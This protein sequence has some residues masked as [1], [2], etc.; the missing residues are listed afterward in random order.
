MELLMR[1]LISSVLAMTCCTASAYAQDEAPGPAADT[2]APSDISGSFGG[3]RIEGNV[4]WDKLQAF[5]RNNEKLG[6]GGSLG[7]DGNVNNVITIGPEF[8]YWQPNNHRSTVDSPA[9]DIA[10]QGREIYGAAVRVGFRAGPDLIVF[11]K[12]GYANQKQR[13]Y[14]AFDDGTVGRNSDHVGGYQVGG[15]FQYALHDHFSFAPAN[16]Y[17]SGQYVYSRFDNHTVDQHA[18]AGIGFKFR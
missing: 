18:M 9:N 2:V 7:F 15:G 1:F 12:G 11:G 14:V 6:Y 5:G 17:V 16:M 13:T 4:G 8:S 3:F 10:L